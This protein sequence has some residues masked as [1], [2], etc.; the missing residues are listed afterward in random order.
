MVSVPYSD[1]S[2]AAQHY[3]AEPSNNEAQGPV[4]S[5]R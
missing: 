4:R 2:T 1:D 3:L 5:L